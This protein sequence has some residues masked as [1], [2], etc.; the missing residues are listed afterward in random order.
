MISIDIPV[1]PCYFRYTPHSTRE[2]FTK[3]WVVKSGMFGE[4]AS[5][6]LVNSGIPWVGLLWV[7]DSSRFPPDFLNFV[8][9]GIPRVPRDSSNTQVRMQQGA[10][11]HFQLR[12]VSLQVMGILVWLKNG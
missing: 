8:Q 3:F 6:K 7:P 1:M 2:F 11:V 9:T 10:R 5:Q 12:L 4:I